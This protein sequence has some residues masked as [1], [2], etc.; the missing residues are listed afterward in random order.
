MISNK[1]AILILL[2]LPVLASANPGDVLE[3][4]RNSNNIVQFD[5]TTGA[6]VRTLA[7]GGALN[8]PVGMAIDPSGTSV[9]VANRA[10]NNILQFNLTSGALMNTL[11]GGGLITPMDLTFGA[12]GNLYSTSGTGAQVYRFNGTTGAPMGAFLSGST[13]PNG[14]VGLCFGPGGSLLVSSALT[15]QVLRYD[16]SSGVFQSVFASGNGLSNPTDVVYRPDGKVYVLSAVSN[17]VMRWDSSGNFV[18][19]FAQGGGLN[20][21]IGLAFRF[22]GDLVVGSN[23]TNQVLGYSGVNGSSTGVFASGGGISGTNGVAVISV[24]EPVSLLAVSLGAIGIAARRRK[25]QRDSR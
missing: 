3:S 6:F 20:V 15:N 16:G 21:G 10:S 9:Y 11:S 24:P 8:N 14:P 13:L 18:D 1:Q 12:D 4:G 19:V 23:Q 22:N 17:Q 2:S 25:K 5:G 7:I